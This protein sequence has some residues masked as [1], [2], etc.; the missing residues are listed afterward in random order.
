MH[1]AE[2]LL[3]NTCLYLSKLITMQKKIIRT[4]AGVQYNEHSEPLFKKNES[5]EINRYIQTA[6]IKICTFFPEKY[7]AQ[8]VE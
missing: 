6:N 3:L 7:L 4:I 2:P 8:A 5:I 1:F